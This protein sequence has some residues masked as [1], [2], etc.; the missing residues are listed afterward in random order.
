MDGHIFLK[1]CEYELFAL[2]FGSKGS[3]LALNIPTFK[4]FPK[5]DFHGIDLALNEGYTLRVNTGAQYMRV[6]TLDNN[7]ELPKRIIFSGSSSQCISDAIFQTSRNYLHRNH[8]KISIEKMSWQKA[9]SDI[10]KKDNP[11]YTPENSL[12]EWIMGGNYIFVD[13]LE[14]NIR[15]ELRC[16]IE[17][18]KCSLN[19]TGIISAVYSDPIDSFVARHFVDAYNILKDKI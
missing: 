4:G 16:L 13:K 5:R 17:P 11:K 1:L 6:A 10:M 14:D 2:E 9:L 18:I 8:S 12:D 3:R 15:I 19:A 7:E